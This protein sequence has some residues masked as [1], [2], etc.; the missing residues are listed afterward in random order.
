MKQ[1]FQAQWMAAAY[2]ASE[3]E[4]E[5]ASVVSGAA[6]QGGD[7]IAPL[8][9]YA[10]MPQLSHFQVPYSYPPGWNPQYGGMPMPYPAYPHAFAP[11][12]FGWAPSPQMGSPGGFYSYAPGAQSVYGGGFGPPA[13]EVNH[14]RPILD[15]NG[16]STSAQFTPPAEKRQSGAWDRE[17][18]SARSSSSRPSLPSSSSQPHLPRGDSRAPNRTSGSP[19]SSWRKSGTWIPPASAMAQEDPS[20]PR[21]R[22]RPSVQTTQ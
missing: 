6:T 13:P 22:S 4:W 2:R 18:P 20:T 12:P 10:S 8:S 17:R 14:N 15:Q 19:P 21:G 9:S 11:P 1:Q 5:R 16:R 3:E 7:G